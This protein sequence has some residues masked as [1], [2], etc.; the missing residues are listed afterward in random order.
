MEK[1]RTDRAADGA[2]AVNTEFHRSLIVPEN[3]RR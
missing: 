1:P 2:G 3:V